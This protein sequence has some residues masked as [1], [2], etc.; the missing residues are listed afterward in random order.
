VTTT[1]LW[2]KRTR[3]QIGQDLTAIEDIYAR[4][5]AEAYHHAGDSE[6]PGGTAMVMLGP[7]ADIETWNYIQLSAEAGRLHYGTNDHASSIEV[8][9]IKRDGTEPPLSFLAGWVDI[10]RT[11]RAQPTGPH[12]ATLDTEISYLRGALDWITSVDHDTQKPWWDDA[13]NFAEQLHN[14][15]RT[16]EEVLREGEQR[17]TG[18][19][20]LDETCEGTR[21]VK[22][23]AGTKDRPLPATFDAWVCPKC[24]RRYTAREYVLFCKQAGRLYADRLHETDML[25]VYRVQP[26]T[27]RKWVQ[28]GHVRKRGRDYSGRTLYDVA[29][30]LKQR[31][32]GQTV[33]PSVTIQ[34]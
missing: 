31:D 15:R 9:A 4:L 19:P 34:P 5:R 12:H 17:D 30:T 3:L 2:A 20:C 32:A 25:E 11:Q 13:D 26:G 6:I 7:R 27:L 33:E 8:D 28:R 1:N 18:A 21:L 10:I 14:V 23:W 29:D 24:K 22:E 16:L